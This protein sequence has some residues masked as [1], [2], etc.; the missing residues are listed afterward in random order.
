VGLVYLGLAFSSFRLLLGS[1]GSSG[2]QQAQDWTARLLGH[3][4]GGW[5]VG[6]AGAAFVANGIFQLYRACSAE[7]RDELRLGEMDAGQVD[8]V[9]KLGRAG[10]AAR[11]VAFGLIG[12]F[13]VQAAL[14][15]EP[16]EARG[17]DGA[18]A[19]LAEQPFGPYLLGLVGAGLAAYGAFALIE[20]RYRRMLLR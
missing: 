19:I 14:H 9:T 11:G 1:T 18:L 2:T 7:F 15:R 8:W 13:L 10:Y 4:L 5:L 3:P 6:L 17:L 20:A 12:L 16:G